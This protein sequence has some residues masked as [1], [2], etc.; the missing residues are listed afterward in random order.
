MGV[1]RG[2]HG[3][4][5]DENSNFQSCSVLR[6]QIFLHLT[7]NNVIIKNLVFFP[8]I[9]KKFDSRVNTYFEFGFGNDFYL[10]RNFKIIN[11]K[12]LYSTG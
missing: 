2:I 10:K 12:K 6:N 11:R 9:I 1:V 3:T 7:K 4:F 5:Y 8:L